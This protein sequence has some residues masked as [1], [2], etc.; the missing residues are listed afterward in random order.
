MKKEIWILRLS[1]KF[2]YERI[3]SGSFN[4]SSFVLE[5]VVTRFICDKVT[6]LNDLFD[7]CLSSGRRTNEGGREKNFIGDQNT[8]RGILI[9]NN[10]TTLEFRRSCR[11]AE[12]SNNSFIT[13][14]I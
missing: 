1:Y 13:V 14:M 4:A 6:N 2:S 3:I 10:S 12:R 8:N 7:S 11:W 5:V 9:W